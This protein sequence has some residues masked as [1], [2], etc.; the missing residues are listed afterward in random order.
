[1]VCNSIGGTPQSGRGTPKSWYEDNREHLRQQVTESSKNSCAGFA[2]WPLSRGKKLHLLRPARFK[3]PVSCT[4]MKST[5][6]LFQSHRQSSNG[7]YAGGFQH[8]TQQLNVMH[9][10]DDHDSDSSGATHLEEEAH[11]HSSFNEMEMGTANQC[12]RLHR[13]WKPSIK[14]LSLFTSIFLN[15]VFLTIILFLLAYHDHLPLYTFSWY[16]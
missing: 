13:A 14:D 15:C 12:G 9:S 2:S 6:R 7:A 4:S 5:P 16:S 11:L 10:D 3:V 8:S 1:M